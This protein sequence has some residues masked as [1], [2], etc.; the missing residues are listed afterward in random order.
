[1]SYYLIRVGEGS[2]YLAEAIKKG[3]IAIGWNDTGDLTSY[4]EFKDLK[5]RFIDTHTH[6]SA[7]QIG[8]NAGQIYRFVHEMQEGDY[9]LSPLGKGDYAVGVAGRYFYDEKSQDTCPYYHHREVNWL[10]KILHKDDMSTSLAYGLGSSLTIYSLDKYSKELDNL[11]AGKVATPAE[12]P[13]GIRDRVLTSLLELDG[14]E[15]EEFIS[16]LLS[17]IGFQAEPT[18]YTNDKGIDVVGILEVDGIAEITL[19]VQVK[20]YKSNAIGNKDILAMRGALSQGEHACF[21]TLSKFSKQAIEEA[22]AS[23]KIPVK[24][25]DGEDLAGIVLKHFDSL[26]DRYKSKFQIRK[27]KNFNIDDLFES[28][29]SDTEIFSEDLNIK[30][31]TEKLA[32]DTL[33]CAAKEGGFRSAFLSEHAWWAI[34]INKQKLEHIKYLA[35][36][37]VAP[38]SAITHYGELE[39][40]ELYEGGPKYKLYLKAAPVELKQHVKLGKNSKLQI[41]KPRYVKL[42]D[43]LKSKTL[44][45]LWGEVPLIK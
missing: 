12:Q 9:V 25:I 37:Q 3:F 26:D 10:D 17:L 41:Q 15:F 20:R 30:A 22:E 34:T 43:I 39:R 31:K 24:L 44:D 1:M 36:Y 32:W 40:I 16:H 19:R 27:R 4:V 13:E 6:S 8:V 33:V 38:V 18:Q 2:K 14:R 45:E 28:V 35:I 5:Q 7:A 42:N 11:L 29:D 23:G 21:I